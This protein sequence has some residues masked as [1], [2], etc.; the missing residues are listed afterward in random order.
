MAAAPAPNANV[1]QSAHPVAEVGALANTVQSLKQGVDSLAGY[2]GKPLDRAVTFNDLVG[3]GLL[4]VGTTAG[5]TVPGVVPGTAVTGGSTG[6]TTVVNPYVISGFVPGVL[7]GSQVLLGHCFPVTVKFPAQFGN[8][9]ATIASQAGSFVAATGGAV[10]T[11]QRC[12]AG[13][14]PT[15]TA[16][17]ASVGTAVFAAGGHTATF[18][19]SAVTFNEGDFLRIVA[20]ATPDT[21]LAQIFLSLAGSR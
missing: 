8:V 3:T 16:N 18:T 7:T 20:P 15:V 14:D 9:T 11:I 19:G 6:A 13:T 5:G 2:R 21:S 1:P 4:K 17:W 12:A 10:L